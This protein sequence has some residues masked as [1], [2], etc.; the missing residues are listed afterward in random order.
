MIM[1]MDG[2]DYM[3]IKLE[4]EFQS[5]IQNPSNN[6]YIVTSETKGYE[7]II[8]RGFSVSEA[9]DDFDEKCR[10]LVKCA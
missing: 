5:D 9:I 8:G 3:D 2:G 4:I 7:D 1:R 10:E 6:R